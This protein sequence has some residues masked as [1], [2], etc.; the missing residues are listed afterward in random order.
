[1]T[2]ILSIILAFLVGI[3]VLLLKICS[4]LHSIREELIDSIDYN[5]EVS[6]DSD[7]R[8]HVMFIHN[9]S[10]LMDQCLRNEDYEQANILKM[11]LVNEI[12]RFDNLYNTE[13]NDAD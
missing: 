5:T 4:L 9:I 3:I 10:V 6:I 7:F 1:M 13:N 11:E 12:K 8:N 2:I